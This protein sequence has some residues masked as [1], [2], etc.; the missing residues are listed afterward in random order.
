MMIRKGIMKD[1]ESMKEIDDV[2]LK[3][4]HSLSYFKKNLKN[5][6][7]AVEQGKVVAYLMVRGEL[8]MNLVVHPDHRGKG[9]GKTLVK[10]AMKKSRRLISRT[11][12]DNVNALEFLKHLGFGY[13]RKIKNYYKNGDTAIEMEWKKT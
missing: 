2:S 3:A 13:K 10:E 6:L 8:A 11:R 9:I 5:I 4:V 1:I 7:V 12:E